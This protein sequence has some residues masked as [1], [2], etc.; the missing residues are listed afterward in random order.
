[1]WLPPA[2]LLLS[3]PGCFSSIQGP[4]SV[5]GPEWGS[6]TVQ[7]HYHPK[8]KSYNK[9]WCRGASWSTC[10]ILARTRG[11]AQEERDRVSIRDNQRNHSLVVTMKR[12]RRGDTDTYWCGI[13]RVGTDHGTPVK[14]TVYPGKD[15]HLCTRW[16]SAQNRRSWGS[17]QLLFKV[18]MA[19]MPSE[20]FTGPSDESSMAVFSESCQ[21][22]HYVLLAFV[23]VPILLILVAAVLWLKGSQ[24]VPEEQWGQAICKNLNSESLTENTTL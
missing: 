21:R 3:L 22:T 7:C 1:M 4:E 14:V 18:E 2:L 11:L 15:F 9:W 5:R 16:P 20:M 24:R 12:L 13:E 6:V 8:W 10:R 19:T 17:K 23:K